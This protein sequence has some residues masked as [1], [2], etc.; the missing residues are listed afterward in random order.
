MNPRVELL[1]A[2]RELLLARSERLRLELGD[3]S[4]ALAL[5]FR[6]ADRIVAR[7]RSGLG[8]VLLVGGAALLL[9]GRP[10][11]ILRTAVRLLMFWPVIRPLLPHL[12]DLWRG[13]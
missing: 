5:R 7:A 6:L 1:S 10:R 12:A 8:Q 4:A 9:F 2:R 3:D 13:R 11:R